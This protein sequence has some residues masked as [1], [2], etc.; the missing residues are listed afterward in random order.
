MSES[1][2]DFW[3]RRWNKVVES[4]LR[5][6]VYIPARKAGLSRLKGAG[7]TF[8]ASGLLHEYMLLYM[9]TRGKSDKL[10]S[11]YR[12]EYGSH[13]LFFLWCGVVLVLESAFCKHP[14]VLTLKKRL[15]RPARTFLVLLTV[16]PIGHFFTDEY[17]AN[18]FYYDIAMGFPHLR[19]LK[20][21][22]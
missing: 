6:G 20:S 9:T 1:P 13:L 22:A 16:L 4:G 17:V 12:P 3:G 2:S 15:I 14:V 11:D 19:V 10:P 7:L 18:F 21:D 8:L 5:R